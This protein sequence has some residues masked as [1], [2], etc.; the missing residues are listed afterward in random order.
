MYT[1]HIGNKR[2]SSWSLRGWLLLKAFDL[3]FEERLTPMYTEAF[4][5]LPDQIAPG[6]QVPALIAEEDGQR[7]VIWDSLAIA[8]FLA[9]RHPEAGHWPSDPTARAAARC[10]AAEM[11]SGFGAL[12]ENMKMNLRRSFPGH[13]RG[14]GVAEDIARMIQLWDWAQTRFGGDGPWLFGDRFTAA[15]V[16]FVPVALRFETYGVEVPAAQQP[17]YQQ[18]LAAPG[19]SDWRA[20]AAEEPWVERR[21]DYD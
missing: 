9:E 6:R 11:H 1:L 10:L 17:Y 18:L 3:P 20:A 2:Y 19:L 14:A 4:A 13:G 16:F 7:Q 5:A 15:D 8:E 21:Y 12:R